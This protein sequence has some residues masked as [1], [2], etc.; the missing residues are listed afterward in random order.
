MSLPCRKACIFSALRRPPANP[1]RQSLS[2]IDES[3]LEITSGTHNA[4]LIVFD[5]LGTPVINRQFV[6]GTI[7]QISVPGNYALEIQ[8]GS[9][10]LVGA[11]EVQ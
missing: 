6:G 5:D 2:K 1:Y 8:S 10:T 11:F 9:L 7:E 3:T 4:Q